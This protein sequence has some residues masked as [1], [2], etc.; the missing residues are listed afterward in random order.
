MKTII[1]LPDDLLREAEARAAREG[2]TLPD[3]VAEGLRALLH[4]RPAPT[5]ARGS[6]GAWARE[7]GGNASPDVTAWDRLRAAYQDPFPGLTAMQMLDEF[8]GP[9]ELPPAQP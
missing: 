8:R 9:V 1:E 3:L 2:Q 7:F 5:G 6:A 4:G